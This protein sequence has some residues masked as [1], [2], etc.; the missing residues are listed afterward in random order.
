MAK[1]IVDGLEKKLEGK[2]RVIRL[3]LLSRVGQEAAVRYGV[4]AVPTLIV[5]NGKGET[6]YGQYG[7]PQPSTVITKVDAILASP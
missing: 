4:R 2:A 5:V 1:S 6:V 3:N 7:L